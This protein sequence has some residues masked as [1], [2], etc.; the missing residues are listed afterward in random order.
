MKI[1]C[2][3]YKKDG[4]LCESENLDQGMNGRILCHDCGEYSIITRA[5]PSD[6]LF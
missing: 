5:A 6:S 4:S 2:P 1:K 3:G